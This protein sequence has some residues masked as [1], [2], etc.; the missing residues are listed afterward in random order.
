[1]NSYPQEASEYEG[2]QGNRPICSQVME[3]YLGLAG[4]QCKLLNE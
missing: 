4:V 2:T 3:M 1:M